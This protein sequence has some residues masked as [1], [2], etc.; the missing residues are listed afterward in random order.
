MNEG[1][2]NVTA[3]TALVNAMLWTTGVAGVLGCGHNG[4]NKCVCL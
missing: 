2:N 1:T 4:D 3:E